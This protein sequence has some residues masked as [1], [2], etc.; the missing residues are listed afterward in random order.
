MDNALMFLN[1]LSNWAL[2]PGADAPAEIA[3]APPA[4]PQ[5][6]AAAPS[7]PAVR[8]DAF[9]MDQVERFFAAPGFVQG[10]VLTSE[11]VD[12]NGPLPGRESARARRKSGGLAVQFGDGDG[13]GTRAV[14]FAPNDAPDE[15]QEQ[16]SELQSLLREQDSLLRHRYTA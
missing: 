16:P 7:A 1:R 8:A 9:T 15:L 14:L 5:F 3:K 10:N 12:E 4:R 6:P 2:G 11:I 13:G